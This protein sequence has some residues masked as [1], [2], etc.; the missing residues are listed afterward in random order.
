MPKIK[1]RHLAVFVIGQCRILNSFSNRIR[2]TAPFQ[3]VRAGMGKINAFGI[4][5]IEGDAQ[6]DLKVEFVQNKTINISGSSN[7]IVGDSNVATQSVRDLINAIDSSSA[8]PEQK[9]EAKSLLRS[10]LEHPL[11]AAVAGGAVGLLG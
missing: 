7:V 6:P 8:T 9:A 4:D 10:F 5:V 3:V 2:A 1:N 11:V